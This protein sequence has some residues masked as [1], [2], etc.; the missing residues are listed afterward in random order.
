MLYYVTLLLCYGTVCYAFFFRKVSQNCIY[1]TELSQD[2][3]L[4]GNQ[5]K[6]KLKDATILPRVDIHESATAILIVI[7][8]PQSVHRLSFTHPI[9][10]VT[11][12][13]A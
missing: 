4:Y 13:K 1:L 12:Y 5:L 11:F 8:T 6:L 3:H 7:A 9:R 10:Q 2:L